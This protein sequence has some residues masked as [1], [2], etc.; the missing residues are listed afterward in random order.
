MPLAFASPNKSQR[1]MAS[2][3]FLAIAVVT[4]SNIV[5]P[6]ALAQSSPSSPDEQAYRD[7]VQAYTQNHFAE[8]ISKLG[9]I[10]GAHAGEAKKYIDNIKAYKE[11]ME[12]A[13]TQMARSS[14]ELDQDNLDFAIQRYQNALKIKA[15]GPWQ[16][17]DKLNKAIALKQRIL[18]QTRASTEA[19]DKN[20][21]AKALDASRIYHFKDAAYLACA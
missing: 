13:D 11:D 6:F 5:L 19:R 8:A 18:E 2:L 1:T 9:Q 16:P 4:G 3:L 20:L 12:L 21:C 17:K 10:S 7:A 14:D 15:D